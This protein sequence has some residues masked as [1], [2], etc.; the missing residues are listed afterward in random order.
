MDEIYVFDVEGQAV[1]FKTLWQKK[2]SARKLVTAL[3]LNVL[4]R[5]G[6]S[7]ERIVGG[8]SSD[9]D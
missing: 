4:P 5:A 1:L 8:N 7:Y 2:T 9:G 3:W 6:C